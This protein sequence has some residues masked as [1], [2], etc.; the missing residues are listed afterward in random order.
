MGEISSTSI[1]LVSL[2]IVDTRFLEFQSRFDP[3]SP[4]PLPHAGEPVG[5]WGSLLKALLQAQDDVSMVAGVSKKQAMVLR[6]AGLTMTDL[7]A[8]PSSQIQKTAQ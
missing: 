2:N 3:S 8:L 1:P 7:A 4:P 5:R 6:G